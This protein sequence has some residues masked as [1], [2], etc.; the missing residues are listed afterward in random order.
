[1]A[2][3]IGLKRERISLAEQDFADGTEA[4]V[5]GH[6]PRY[7]TRKFPVPVAVNWTRRVLDGHQ[8]SKLVARFPMNSN[9]MTEYGGCL[10]GGSTTIESF[11]TAKRVTSINV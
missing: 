9:S 5:V 1:M 2:Y 4:P 10:F 6:D 3:L 8:Q 11:T 7:L